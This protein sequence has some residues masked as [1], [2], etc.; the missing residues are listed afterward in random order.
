[1]IIL[2]NA[3][4]I[5]FGYVETNSTALLVF[6][7]QLK[8]LKF[9]SGK[10]ALYSFTEFLY[11]KFLANEY[12]KPVHSKPCCK[13]NANVGNYC[14]TCG[15]KFESNAFDKYAWDG[16]LWNLMQ[17][18]SDSYGQDAYCAGND[19]WTPYCNLPNPKTTLYIIECG[20]EI[21]TM[22]LSYIHPELKIDLQDHLI[23][24]DYFNEL[25]KR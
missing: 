1:V 5:R 3:I 13:A 20:M 19:E 9:T 23:Y 16:F 18:N 10:D 17:S 2:I 7:P 11:Q 12:V 21:I 8:K 22:A 6:A 14:S 24:T 15:M 25:L 4:A